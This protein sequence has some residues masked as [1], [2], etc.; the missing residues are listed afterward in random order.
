MIVHRIESGDELLGL[1]G[2]AAESSRVQA[3]LTQLARGMQPQLD[4]EDDDAFV[5]WVTVNEIG[6][7][8]G[9][10]DE[11]YVR[12]LDIDERRRSP[13]LLTQLYFYGDTPKTQPFP[14]A[15]P[16]GL[17][18]V[19]DRPTVHRK[20]A[21]HDALRRSYVR[22]AWRLPAFD[23]TIAYRADDGRLESVLCAVPYAPWPVRADEAALVAPFT[24]ETLCTLFGAR[25]SSA[26]IRAQLE[27]LGYARA[28]P[29]VRSEHS[30]D[31]RMSHGIEFGFAPG[32]QVPAADLQFP[33]SLALASVT[34][35]GPRVYDAR[36]WIGPMPMGLAFDDSQAQ[37][38]AKMGRKP[39]D[40]RDFDRNGFALWHF[41]NYSL[42]TE[43]SNIENRLLRA[44]LMAPGYWAATS[45]GRD[46]G[47]GT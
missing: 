37:I 34:Y 38:A 15:L 31:L 1:L 12:A 43:Y 20:L 33:R 29:D 42:R 44:T 28:L 39:D 19:D 46:R 23:L 18:F 14:Y 17:A 7:E 10:E 25:W 6:L 9:F 41:Q 26:S 40:R 3:T 13:L 21:A 35:Y 5:D 16:F 22:D 8:F 36:E 11:A 27:P 45:E 4:P 32:T 30:A 2:L 24:P 47:G